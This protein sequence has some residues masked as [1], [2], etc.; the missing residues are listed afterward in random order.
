[1]TKMLANALHKELKPLQERYAAL[2]K[3]LAAVLEEQ[4]A[5]E[6]QLA[7]PQVYADHNRSNELLR[8]FDAHKQRSEQ[9]LEEMTALEESLQE[10]RV[11]WGEDNSA[12]E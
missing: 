9:L 3:D 11:R 7:D 10:T 1:M 12:S 5:V 8:A 6:A 4:S 2:E